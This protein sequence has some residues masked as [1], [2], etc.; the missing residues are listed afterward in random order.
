[1]AS[2]TMAST[3]QSHTPQ[4]PP[5]VN[6]RPLQWEGA[7]VLL[8]RAEQA[9]LDAMLR[10]SPTPEP[11]LG[12]RPYQGED[13]QDGN[14]TEPDEEGSLTQLLSPSIGNITAATLRYATKKKLRP[15]QRDDLESFL[16]VSH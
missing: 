5:N 11:V 6:G 3:A 9:L 16:Q 15:E 1:M 13:P 7:V 14:D 4:P 2:T 8:S 12:K 10:S